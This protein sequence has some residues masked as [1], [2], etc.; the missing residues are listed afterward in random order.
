MRGRLTTPV[1]L[2]LL[3]VAVVSPPFSAAIRANHELIAA[4]PGCE[5]LYLPTS[6][7][8]THVIVVSARAEAAPRIERRRL[9]AAAARGVVAR[10]RWVGG[11]PCTTHDKRPL[12]RALDDP[13][14]PNELATRLELVESP[15]S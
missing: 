5:R 12:P 13:P 7:P 11:R 9:E 4:R 10:E 8:L 15:V 6:S 1:L 2:W 3:V 14:Q